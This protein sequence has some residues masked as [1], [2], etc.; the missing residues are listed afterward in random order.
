[1]RYRLAIFDF[2]GTLASSLGGIWEAMSDTLMA[3]GYSAPSL[4]EVRATAGLT[5]GDSI[6]SLTKRKASKMQIPQIEKH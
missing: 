4:E 6:R 5:L 2:D 1:M 3:F